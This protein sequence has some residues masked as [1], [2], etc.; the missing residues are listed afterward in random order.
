M[1]DANGTF[2]LTLTCDDAVGIVAAVTGFL[3]SH[4]GFIVESQQ[5]ADLS[6]GRFFARI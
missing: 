6:S 5:Y 4:D 1:P 2:V 3:A